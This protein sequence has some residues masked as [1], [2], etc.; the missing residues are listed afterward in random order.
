[1]A[2]VIV[3]RPRIGSR[4]SSDDPKGW[5]RRRYGKGNDPEDLPSKESMSR[6]RK[7]GD[8]KQLN[9]HLRPLYRYLDKQVGRPWDKVFSEICERINMNSTVQRHIMQHVFDHVADKLHV[10]DDGV[11]MIHYSFG[12]FRPIYDSWYKL[13]VHPVDGLLKK[14]KKPKNW[15]SKPWIGAN[16]GHQK[17]K[18]EAR[19]NGP[20]WKE[21][22]PHQFHKIKG[23]W[24]IAELEPIPSGLTDEIVFRDD[25]GEKT[26]KVPSANGKIR[27]A[28]LGRSL[29][30][31]YDE[32]TKKETS[33]MRSAFL[34][35]TPNGREKYDF[36]DETLTGLYGRKGVYAKS[37]KQA[38]SKDLKWADLKN[39]PQEAE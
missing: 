35:K 17:K 11:P 7:Y 25:D 10:G 22:R 23:I 29:Y 12:G 30:D 13:Y 20:D 16:W 27:D 9:E 19:A 18:E 34:G 32:A 8:D 4:N 5:R 3:E 28:M 24:Y 21:T 39:D 1:M 33:V 15:K 6:G 14:V 37:F 36:Y 2:K 38:N 26:M 31:L